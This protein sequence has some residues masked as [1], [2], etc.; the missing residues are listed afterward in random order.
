VDHGYC[1]SI[2][3]KAPD[4]RKLAFTVDVPNAAAIA[5]MRRKDAHAELARWLAGDRHTN[6]GD[7]PH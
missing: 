6:N 5:A 3:I 7:R 1:T 4:D 2:Y